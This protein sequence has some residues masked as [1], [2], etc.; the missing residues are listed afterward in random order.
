[1]KVL[2]FFLILAGIFSGCDQHESI[3]EPA[4]IL[5]I[6]ILPSAYH[7]WK[8]NGDRIRYV[9]RQQLRD[10]FGKGEAESVTPSNDPSEP[11]A[12]A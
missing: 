3:T 10:I 5:F 9:T 7:I 6:S 2:T 12:G 11:S 4:L 1:M 8:E